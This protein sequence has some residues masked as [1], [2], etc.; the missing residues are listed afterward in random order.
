MSL[1]NNTI[2]FIT[3]FNKPKTLGF[4][5]F[6]S[7]SVIVTYV[8]AQQ[9]FILEKE[10]KAEM[11]N[12]LKVIQ[13]DLE[14]TLKNSYTTALTLALT[15]NDQGYPINFNTLS[16]KLI[17]SNQN[18][19][20]VQLVPNGVIT[21]VYPYTPNKQALGLNILTSR[22]HRKE[23]LKSISSQKMYFAG[24]L[25]LLQG[26][27]GIVGRLPVYNNDKFWG[28]SAVVIRIE[29]LFSFFDHN[30]LSNS[31]YYLQLSKRNPN[32]NKEVF[33]LKGIREFKNLN[34]VSTNIPDGDWTIYLIEKESKATIDTTIIMLA[35]FGYILSILFGFITTSVLQKPRE[36]QILLEKQAQIL[37]NS[38]LKF[39]SFFDQA[40][41]GIANVSIT[42]GKFI[43][44]NHKFASLLGYTP[45]EMKSKNFMEITHPEDLKNDMEHLD[46]L[47][48][49][50]INKYSIEKRYYKKNG[51]I[52]WVKLTVS[53]LTTLEGEKSSFMAIV[54]NISKRKVAEKKSKIYQQRIESLI[55]TIDGIVWECNS[56][57]FNFTFIS[58][59]VEMILGYTSE[60]WL[61]TPNFWE[62][63]I[64][65]DDKFSTL[66]YCNEKTRS[67]V[68]HDFEYR[69]IAKDGSVVWL[70]D[71]VNVIRENNTV[72]SLRGIMIDI[73]KTKEIQDELNNSFELVTE[74]NK[75]L[76]NFSYIVSHNLRS[77]TSNISSL[78]DLIESSDNEEETREYVA[79]L[80][81]VSNALNET[82]ENLNEVVNIQS[83]LNL[84]VESINLKSYID[85]TLI[86]VA[87]KIRLKKAVINS[88]VNDAIEL[89]YNP[90]YLESI[91]YNLISNA[92]RYSHPDRRPEVNI[93]I[94]KED[95][96]NVLE[97]T[98]N[99]IGI[100]LER[101]GS[102]IFGMYKTFSNNPES[103]GIGLFITKNQIDAMGGKVIIESQPNIGTTFKIYIS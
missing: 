25:D 103:R 7:L 45:K 51:K 21:Y 86:I 76:L 11:N 23:A 3:R 47:V 82:L 73:T 97:V 15:I 29:Q 41:V 28:F 6:L 68:D 36:L 50:N 98:D 81:N 40:A 8:V 46:R 94:T 33:Y 43:A 78:T 44:I 61:S 64:H 10:K 4:L 85:N 26:G 75:R 69:M 14:K 102:K 32:T 49:G 5:V 53:Y 27:K 31:N 71:I 79:L 65:P 12:D 34:Y 37:L 92:I 54:E 96:W 84:V 39:K 2:N 60:E 38:E 66:N 63:H 52:I 30:A 24:P 101:H 89:T 19:S 88:T 83:N 58:Q 42:D 20:S 57:T 93:S 16:K 99:G 18:I 13:Q 62:T 90:A 100:D 17:E 9:H 87:D 95:N 70:R 80:K 67:R 1:I 77:H 91:L 72:K 55:N 48:Q 59:K 22:I 56:D 74:Q 35:V